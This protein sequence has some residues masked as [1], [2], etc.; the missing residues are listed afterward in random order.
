MDNEIVYTVHVVVVDGEFEAT[1]FD[2]E[3][4]SIAVVYADTVPAA[5]AKLSTESE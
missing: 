1:L 5:L 2:A 4:D 3:G